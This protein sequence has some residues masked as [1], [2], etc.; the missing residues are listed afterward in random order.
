MTVRQRIIKQG[1]CAFCGGRFAF[2]REVDAQ[3]GRV[4]G[5]DTLESVAEDYSLTVRSM[6]RGWAALFDLLNEPPR[7]EA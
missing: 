3:L 2:H 4:I 1:P 7:G 5:G 6:L